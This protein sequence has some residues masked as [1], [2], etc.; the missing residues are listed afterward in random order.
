MIRI[1]AATR[2]PGKI[3]EIKEIL[4][5]ADIISLSD[6]E[7]NEEIP[8]RGSTFYE[9]ALL[10]ASWIRNLYKNIYPDAFILADDS[11]LEIDALGG[12]PGVLSA[13]YSG[14]VSGILLE[15]SGI[16]VKKRKARFVCCMVLISP[17]GFI[18]SY[19][20]YCTGRISNS[21]RG[22]N[23]FGYDPIFLIKSLGYRKTMAE[24]PENLKN[25]I[26]HRRNAINGLKKIIFKQE[27]K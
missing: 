24:I 11:G 9:N 18:Y 26:S 15:M 22:T 12:R 19:E 27:L 13:R 4:Y 6:I 2:N 23:G 8:E 14:G 21:I 1:I 3:K 10:K 16:P 7:F 5:P 17:S 20:G 25:S